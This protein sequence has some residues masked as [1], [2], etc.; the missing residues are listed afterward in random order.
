[1]DSAV[2]AR[3][4]R[5]NVQSNQWAVKITEALTLYIVRLKTVESHR[6]LSVLELTYKIY[7]CRHVIDAVW[8]KLSA[9]GHFFLPSAS[10]LI[11]EL[12]VSAQCLSSD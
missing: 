6:L 5:E 1:M 12:A 7:S 4:V 10:P 8:P 11:F 9:G 3:E 2:N